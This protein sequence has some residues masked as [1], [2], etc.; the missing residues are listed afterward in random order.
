MSSEMLEKFN[1]FFKV[2]GRDVMDTL[3]QLSQDAFDDLPV[4]AILLNEKAKIIKYNRTEGELTNRDP[5]QVIGASFFLNLAVCGVSEQFQ[6]RFNR[7]LQGHGFRLD[8]PPS[9]F[10]T[11][12]PKCL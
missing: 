4:G 12:C 1:Q 6:G 2:D 11:K 5:K 3:D 7:A 9:C 8:V 10:F